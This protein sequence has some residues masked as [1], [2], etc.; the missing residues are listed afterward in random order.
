MVSDSRLSFNTFTHLLLI[1]N[2][3]QRITIKNSPASKAVTLEAGEILIKFYF[4]TGFFQKLIIK[5]ATIE[6]TITAKK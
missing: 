6:P 1:C 5:A 2:L 3:Q 4:S